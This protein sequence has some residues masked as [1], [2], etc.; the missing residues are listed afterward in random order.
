MT[1]LV[2]LVMMAAIEMEWWWELCRIAD[3]GGGRDLME[4]W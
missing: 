2:V 1:E 3:G 4:A